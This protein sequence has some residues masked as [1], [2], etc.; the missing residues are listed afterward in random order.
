MKHKWLRSGVSCMQ[1]MNA[2]II[3]DLEKDL[4]GEK[5]QS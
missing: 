5:T 3:T 1:G 2:L 4:L